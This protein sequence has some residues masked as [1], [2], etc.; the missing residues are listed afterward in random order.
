MSKGMFDVNGLVK[1]IRKK[2]ATINRNSKKLK[3][4]PK[5][6]TVGWDASSGKYPERPE[7]SVSY[8]AYLH[9]H[10]TKDFPAKN[11]IE[12]TVFLHEDQWV[13]LYRKLAKKSL[14]KGQVPDYYTIAETVGEQM[15]RDLENYIYA[16]DLVDTQRLA[17]SVIVRYSRR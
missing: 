12:T 15:K 1:G 6:I 3:S 2:Q 5:Y 16:I 10:G 8:V 4:A 7:I 9:E 13:K 11:M 17:N 14:S